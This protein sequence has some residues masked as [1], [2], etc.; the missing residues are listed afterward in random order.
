MARA[1]SD[2][3]HG[4]PVGLNRFS[5]DQ[6]PMIGGAADVVFVLLL[7]QGTAG[8]VAMLGEALFMHNP[9]YAVL[10]LL[11]AGLLAMIAAKIVRGRRWA[12]VTAI[13]VQWLALLG[14][15]LG[16]LVGLAPGLAPS[17]TLTGLLTEVALPIAVTAL[18]AQLLAQ[19]GV[20]R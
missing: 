17:F 19:N 20:A 15:G 8:V 2:V 3:D 18:C 10:P 13:V 4:R 9:V 1:L 5:N 14:V 11:R 16:V 7:L 12:L 6:R